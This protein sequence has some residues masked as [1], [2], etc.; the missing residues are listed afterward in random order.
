MSTI[1]SI[2]LTA[3]L[4]MLRQWWAG[5]GAI[6]VPE[7]LLPQGFL[8]SAGGVD[9]AAVF[10]Y[11]DV[12][13]RIAVVEY[14]TT[15]PTVSFSRILVDEVRKLRAHVEVVALAQAVAN[16]RPAITMLSFVKPSSGE[17]RLLARIGYKADDSGVPHKIMAK[18]L[19]KEGE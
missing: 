19:I 14:L 18:P 3:D 6:P 2:D 12:S 5:H 17:E 13:G 9:I 10:L 8:V 11:L 7:Y 16:G 1:R 4:P 15:N